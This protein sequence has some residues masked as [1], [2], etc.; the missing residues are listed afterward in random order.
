MAVILAR[1]ATDRFARRSLAAG[2]FSRVALLAARK[3]FSLSFGLFRLLMPILFDRYFAHG[4]LPEVLRQG[5]EVEK[6]LE[7]SI[8]KGLSGP[9]KNTEKFS[10]SMAVVTCL[11]LPHRIQR[12]LDPMR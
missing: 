8:F 11:S 6:I 9:G 4:S 1:T 2:P 10:R 5:L 12:E 7:S 3:F